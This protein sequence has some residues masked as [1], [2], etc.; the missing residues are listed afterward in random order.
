MID[1]ILKNALVQS[2][3]ETCVEQDIV[4]NSETYAINKNPFIIPLE[5]AYK[6][7]SRFWT[8]DYLD[9]LIV[10]E[11]SGIYLPH[12]FM[13][14]FGRRF[15]SMLKADV[16]STRLDLISR[17]PMEEPLDIFPRGKI[18]DMVADAVKEQH[19]STDEA[20]LLSL[21]VLDYYKPL[22]FLNTQ[23]NGLSTDTIRKF[24]HAHDWLIPLYLLFTTG[25]YTEIRQQLAAA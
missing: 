4:A 17:T 5:M 1:S 22:V 18:I 6:F 7:S 8:A 10:N 20:L 15:W 14:E 9:D 24:L 16:F 19:D 21:E 11:T 13:M 23:G 12:T 25:T 2:F 3:T